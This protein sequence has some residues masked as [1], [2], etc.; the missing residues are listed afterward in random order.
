MLRNKDTK[1]NR[2]PRRYVTRGLAFCLALVALVWLFTRNSSQVA[3]PPATVPVTFDL[4][5]EHLRNYRVDEAERVLTAVLE[6]HP[7]SVRAREE[8]RWLY[9]NQFRHHELEVLLED[10]LRMRPTDFSLAV[11]LL[12]SEFRP[13]N[14]REVLGH[15]ERAAEQQPGEARV[16]ATLGYCYARVGDIPRAER[17]FQAALDLQPDDMLVIVRVVEFLIDQGSWSL[18]EQLLNGMT[19]EQPP[20]TNDHLYQDYLWWYQSQFAEV[21][22]NV[23]LAL[24]LIERSTS[25]RPHELRYVQRRGALLQLLGRTQEAA[26]CFAQANRLESYI[27]RLTEI[28]LSGDLDRPSPELC[29]EIAEICEQRGKAL[30]AETWKLASQSLER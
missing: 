17:T 29:R 25:R 18:A 9:F 8:L 7:E 27:G 1:P 5:M 23:P 21:R 11:A 22:G 20:A 12:M 16:L 6:A 28:V 14:A 30:Q 15:W 2:G 26:D 3:A 19:M 13:Q 4:A 24:E 10:G